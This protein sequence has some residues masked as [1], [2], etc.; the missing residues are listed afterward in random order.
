MKHP[1]KQTEPWRGVKRNLDRS[2]SASATKLTKGP[3]NKHNPAAI[4][5]V[6]ERLQKAILALRRAELWLRFEPAAKNPSEF[7][8]STERNNR[9]Q[10]SISEV[11]E[12]IVS[13]RAAFP[14]WKRILDLSGVLLTLPC[15]LPVMILVSL[16]IKIVS[17]GPIFYW[18]QRVGYQRKLFKIFKFRTMHVNVDTR[19]H[20]THFERLMVSD[21]PMTKLDS[22]DT[23]LIRFGRFLR[24]T[25][26]DELPQ[27]FNV[28]QGEMSLVGPRPC[29]ACEFD[30]YTASQ[31]ER[32]NVPPGLTGYWQVNGKNSTTFSQMISMDLFYANNMSLRLDLTVILRTVPALLKQTFEAHILSKRGAGK[33]TAKPQDAAIQTLN[34]PAMPR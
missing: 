6:T 22:G 21:R 19:V 4:R 29:L 1:E 26:L 30:R 2:V 16:W 32:S 15:W 8:D 3:R 17:P 12:K 13:P 24:S 27:I 20:E 18:Q 34:R 10:S 33:K 25:G 28:L 5:G 9:R 31:K 23:R 11:K 7:V 14:R